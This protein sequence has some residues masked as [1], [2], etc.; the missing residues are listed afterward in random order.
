MLFALLTEKNYQVLAVLKSSDTAKH[1]FTEDGQLFLKIRLRSAE[2][3]RH[4]Q[5]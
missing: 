3:A 2:Y 4:K 1:L 5:L